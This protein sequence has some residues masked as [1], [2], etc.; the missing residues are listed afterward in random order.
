MLS[1]CIKPG[2]SAVPTDVHVAGAG[3]AI[4]ILG[5]WYGNG[6]DAEGPWAPT[7]EKIDKAL[8]A[9]DHSHPTIEGRRLIIQMIVGGMTQYLTQVQGMPK[10]VEERLSKRIRR[11]IWDEKKMS[12]VSMDTLLAP[13]SDGG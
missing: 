7:L 2:G 8:D 9:W 13:F 12:P 1:R 6:F 4:R 10:S 11:Y 5:A 3:E